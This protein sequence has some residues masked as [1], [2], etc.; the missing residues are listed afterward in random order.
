VPKKF[1]RAPAAIT[2]TSP[3]HVCPSVAVTVFVSGSIAAISASL[4][5]TFGWLRNTLRS[6]NATL[7]GASCEVAT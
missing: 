3:L 7:P 5:S 4:T 1:A 2:S 6:E